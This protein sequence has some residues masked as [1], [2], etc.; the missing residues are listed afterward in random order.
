MGLPR[1]GLSYWTALPGRFIRWQLVHAGDMI[2]EAAC[3]QEASSPRPGPYF[4]ELK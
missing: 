3:H 4:V 2:A 1:N